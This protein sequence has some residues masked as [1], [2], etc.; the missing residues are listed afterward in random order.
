MAVEP[1]HDYA[2]SFDYQSTKANEYAWVGGY[3]GAAGAVQTQ[4][5][6]FPA[7]HESTRWVQ[8]FTASA[9]GDSY[10]GLLIRD[11]GLLRTGLVH[12]SR[13]ARPDPSLGRVLITSSPLRWSPMSRLPSPTRLSR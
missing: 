8:N 1:G 9:C 3:D 4:S 12:S 11:V 5:T 7:K 10:V 13:V 6:P 2:I